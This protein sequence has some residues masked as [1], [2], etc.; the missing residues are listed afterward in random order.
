VPYGV[1][2]TA[3]LPRIVVTAADDVFAQSYDHIERQSRDVGCIYPERVYSLATAITLLPPSSAADGNDD[4][5]DD[6]IL[7]V[8]HGNVLS[9]PALVNVSRWTPG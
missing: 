1:G 5:D 8:Q 2:A 3:H 7:F 9:S 6:G 4:H